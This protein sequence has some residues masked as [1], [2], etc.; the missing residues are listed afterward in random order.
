MCES[1]SQNN[2]DTNRDTAIEVNADIDIEL[3]AAVAANGVIGR[4]GGMPW[5]IP[6]D[7]QQFK[8]RTMDHPVILGRR[9]YEAI[10]DALGEPFPGRTS[11]V[12]SS[13]SRDMPPG[14]ILTH[15]IQ[16]AIHEASED[17]R[18]RGVRTVYI[19]GGGGVYEQFLSVADRLRLTELHEEYDGDTRFPSW[20]HNTWKEVTR[21]SHEKFDFVTY[22]RST[23]AE[24]NM[25]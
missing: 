4:D 22:E 2:E 6:A 23:S 7:L 14:A 20:D 16:S 11:I 21:E 25:Q 10:V 9:T 12:L 8:Q 13:Q 5:H 1:N 19:A 3:I 17:A 18:E 24:S 15:S